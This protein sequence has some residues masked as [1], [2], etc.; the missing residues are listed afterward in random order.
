M[1]ADGKRA[2]VTGAG[3]GLGRAFSLALAEAGADLALTEL[4]GKEDLAEEV[5]AQV[6]AM[7]RRAAVVSLDVN[8]V[9]RIGP[10]ISDARDALGGLDVLVNNAGIN[11]PRWALEV[12]EEDRDRVLDTN[13]KGAFFVAQ[14]VGRVLVEQG[15]GGKIVNIDSQNGL[16]GYWYRAAHCSAKAGLVNLTRVLAIEGAKHRITVN[17]VAPTFVHTPLTAR[18]FEDQTFYDDVLSRIPLGRI[19]QPEEIVGAVVYLASD[20]A[21]M[22]TGHTLVVDGGWTA[23]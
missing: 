6:R 17:A 2:L 21:D 23:I 3:S 14:A 12:T 19:A 15:R 5:A 1:R 8:S 22:V 4:P 10:A 9:P 16:I 20:A 7:S 13:L 11:I 18:M